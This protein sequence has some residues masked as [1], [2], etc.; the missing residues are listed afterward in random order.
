VGFLQFMDAGV[1]YVSLPPPEQVQP[2]KQ[3]TWY[4]YIGSG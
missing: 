3:P 2:A 4:Q 1:G